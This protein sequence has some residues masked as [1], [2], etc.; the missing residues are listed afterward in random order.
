MQI[1]SLGGEDPLEEGMAIHASVLAWR[2]P[3]TE[4]PGRLQPIGSHRIR[5][6]WSDFARTH[7][8]EM[9]ICKPSRTSW[10]QGVLWEES[11]EAG[12]ALTQPSAARGQI[13]RMQWDY[14]CLKSISC[15]YF[16]WTE[17]PIKPIPVRALYSSPIKLKT[18][19]SVKFFYLFF[20][21]FFKTLFLHGL[22]IT[23]I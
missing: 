19:D 2:I 3:W 8:M 16:N 4:E 23:V 20:I 13:V 5:H 17:R 21:S 12:Q 1:W 6:N 9:G 11:G 14:L 10:S 15:P 18:F 7:D 22:N